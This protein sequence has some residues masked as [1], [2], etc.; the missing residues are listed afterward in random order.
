MRPVYLLRVMAAVL[1]T[2]AGV[3]IGAAQVPPGRPAAGKVDTS[4]WSRYGEPEPVSLRDIVSHPQLYQQRMVR[5]RGVFDAE[6][7]RTDYR[8]REEHDQVLLLSVAEGN[9][10]EMLRG[11]S[12]DV[13]GVVRKIRPKQYVHGK[14]LDI[15]EDPDLPVLPAPDAGLPA[16]T[17][18]FLSIFDATPLAHRPGTSGDLA[19]LVH[20]TGTAGRSVKVVGQF[21]GANLFGDL[22]DLP[23]RDAEA[24]VLKDGDTAVWVVGK[25]AAGKGFRL[26]PRLRGDSRFWLE[27]EGRLEPC[28]GQTCLRARH[29]LLAARPASEQP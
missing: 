14:D 17:L 4:P 18:S 27:V 24:F 7:D 3:P 1:P 23:G 22:P 21:R 28:A 12:V 25:A 15:I 2:F 16:I 20:A 11:R 10:F 26:D 5:T 6:L 13:V 8:L 29:V 19:D 9:E